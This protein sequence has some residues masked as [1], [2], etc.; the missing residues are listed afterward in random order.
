M[1]RQNTENGIVIKVKNCDM[2]KK[3]NTSIDV[4]VP[5]S[6]TEDKMLNDEPGIPELEL[7]YYDDFDLD[8]GVYRGMTE[9]TRKKM[10]IKR[11]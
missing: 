6:S 2:N 1:T 11:C 4:E 5:I 7:L 9:E 10:Y 3:I 8:E